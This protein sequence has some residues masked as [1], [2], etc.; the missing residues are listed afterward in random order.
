MSYHTYNVYIEGEVVDTDTDL[1]EVKLP[2]IANTTITEVVVNSIDATFG[3]ATIV[4]SKFS[5]PT[6][7][8]SDI[9]VSLVTN[10]TWASQSGTLTS[11]TSFFIKSGT[12]NGLYGVNVSLNFTR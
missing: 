10:A 4:V 5:A 2:L 3:T 8:A 12:P 9:I 11:N 1:I 7:D 6:T